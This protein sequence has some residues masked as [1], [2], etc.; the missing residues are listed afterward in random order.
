M[1][2]NNIAPDAFTKKKQLMR[3]ILLKR[4]SIFRVSA[5]HQSPGQ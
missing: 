1:A 4:F 3:I 2:S 5:K